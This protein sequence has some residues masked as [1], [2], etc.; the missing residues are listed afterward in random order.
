MQRFQLIL[1]SCLLIS[2]C[3]E[4]TGAQEQ[5]RSRSEAVSPV[6]ERA[7]AKNSSYD[8]VA[9][10]AVGSI[11]RYSVDNP[12]GNLTLFNITSQSGGRTCYKNGRVFVYIP[13]PN[14]RNCDGMTDIRVRSR[15]KLS[16]VDAEAE[17]LRCTAINQNSL[18]GSTSSVVISSPDS[19][20]GRESEEYRTL[21]GNIQA[22]VT[23]DGLEVLS[24]VSSFGFICL[25]TDRE[26]DVVRHINNS[27]IPI[28][29]DATISIQQRSCAIIMSEQNSKLLGK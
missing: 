2:A 26:N 16:M 7:K 13:T 3:G 5:V 21:V 19:L 20:E 29:E 25:G 9:A 28:P 18:N 10:A 12:Q 23:N 14:D 27:G 22:L 17:F 15:Q 4:D 8:E 24:Y 1:I 6:S 11:C